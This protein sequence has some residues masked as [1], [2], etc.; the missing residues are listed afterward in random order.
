MGRRAQIT[1]F[2]IVGIILLFS[3]ALLFYIRGQIV[4]GI[5][6]EFVPTI[7]EVPLEAQPIKVFVEDCMQKVGSEALVQL[8]L[9]G[10]YID[11][12][13]F[14]L[15]GKVMR[16]GLEPT[17]SDLLVFFGDND[18]TSVPYWWY[19]SSKN[20][21]GRS[22][23]DPCK[24]D[25]QR[26]PLYKEGGQSS[27]EGQL[28]TYLKKMLN[29]CINDFK[30][31]EV[32]GFDVTVL[33]DL[34]P[35]V[36]VT[37][38]EVIV[39]MEYPIRVSKE[40]RDTSITSFYTKI[41]LNMK[42][43]YTLAELIAKV[44]GRY[45]FLEGTLLDMITVYSIPVSVDKLPPLSY[46]TMDPS[47]FYIWT[48]TETQ[49][50]LESYVLSQFVPV[51]TVAGARNY[52]NK[53]ILSGG[54][55]NDVASGFLNSFVWPLNTINKSQ[56]GIDDDFMFYDMD[57]NFVYSDWWPIYLNI[58]DREILK[59]DSFKNDFFPFLTINTYVFAYDVSYPLVVRIYDP[60]AFEG[61]GYTFMFA[62]EAN[63]RGDEPL[64]PD[65]VTSSPPD[66]VRDSLACNENQRSSAPIK[67]NS[68]DAL[69]GEQ[70]EGV[71][72]EFMM[73][74]QSCFMGHTEL[75]E[76][77]ES[78]LT[79][80]FPIGVGSLKLNKNGYLLYN[81]RFT[82]TRQHAVNKTVE[83]YPEIEI[84]AM[85]RSLPLSYAGDGAYI[86][87]PGSPIAS[88]SPREEAFITFTRLADEGA[89]DFDYTAM[90]LFRGNQTGPSLL[91]M[92]PGTYEVRGH[93]IS[94]NAITIPR[95]ERL[96]EVPFADDQTIVANE[97]SFDSY[98]SGGIEFNNVTGYLEVTA[99]DLVNSDR[100]MF[101]MLRF[102]TP[103]THSKEFKDA[104]SLEALGAVPEYSNIYRT[105]LEPQWIGG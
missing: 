24:Y 99:D 35:D 58:N 38:R 97:S 2:M 45:A 53:L 63:I 103:I 75:D 89:E 94:H 82:T 85:V 28:D 102:P 81:R 101:Y 68:V 61:R 17:E 98:P 29:S 96:Y 6:E 39:V 33:G 65:V 26:P 23:Q 37:E 90:L 69:T 20:K 47:E 91:K 88:L 11:P 60:L 62:M 70:V 42:K 52:D 87:P 59:G 66:P 93:L 54:K 14:E 30:D 105:N 84:D 3:S 32:Q 8:G 55:V 21:C 83:L 31:F 95:E 7:E 71:M 19:L 79:A 15:S 64:L 100:V 77:N 4:T 41:D 13:D 12:K 48:R 34:K 44:E 67:I 46:Q 51:M 1:V 49:E 78:T 74:T 40:G 76:N 92:V 104:P 80:Q 72:V 43:V 18:A 25:S 5:P 10:G 36:R 22:G 56:F 9:H 16:A 86:L 27:V 73:G 50:K 57:V